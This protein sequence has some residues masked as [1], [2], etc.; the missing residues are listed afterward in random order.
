[1]Q[2]PTLA[3]SPAALPTWNPEAGYWQL[4]RESV[5]PIFT[6]LHAGTHDADALL[7]AAFSPLVHT[8]LDCTLDSGALGLHRFLR[9]LL[10]PPQPETT[11]RFLAPGAAWTLL[12]RLPAPQVAAAFDLRPG[13]GPELD[14]FPYV[15][16]LDHRGRLPRFHRELLPLVV[17]VLR[18][19]G[20]LLLVIPPPRAEECLVRQLWATLTQPTHG[21]V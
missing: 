6:S 1:M 2:I 3:S 21:G 14:D 12:A 16:V 10:R 7:C 18:G 4:A 19:W 5:L 8:V 13:G 20:A 17:A 15:P 9:G 11:L